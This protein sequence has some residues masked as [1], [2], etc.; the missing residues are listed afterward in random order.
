MAINAKYVNEWTDYGCYGIGY[1]TD[2]LQLMYIQPPVK[3]TQAIALTFQVP[4]QILILQKQIFLFIKNLL[5]TVY[6]V[7]TKEV[8]TMKMTRKL[9][10]QATTFLKDHKFNNILA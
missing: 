7:Q 2:T 10:N 6:F 8:Y 3:Y 5:I 4:K 9:H 1:C